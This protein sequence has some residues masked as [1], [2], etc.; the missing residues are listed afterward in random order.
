MFVVRIRPESGLSSG[1]SGPEMPQM[2]RE[3]LRVIHSVSV[4]VTHTLW[5]AGRQTHTALN[6]VINEGARRFG[7]LQVDKYR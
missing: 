3:R 6:M 4:I 1:I 2:L 5:M 7:V